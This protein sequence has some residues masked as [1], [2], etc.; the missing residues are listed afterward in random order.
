MLD[1]K[2]SDEQRSIQ[3][4]EYAIICES[5]SL[6]DRG[7]STGSRGGIIGAGGM[8]PEVESVCDNV[9]RYTEIR[10]NTLE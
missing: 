4:L 6:G 10:V 1:I 3:G 2:G 5:V 8:P 7:V 9:E